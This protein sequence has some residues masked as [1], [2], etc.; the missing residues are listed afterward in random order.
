VN[1]ASWKIAAAMVA[2]YFVFAAILGAFVLL[3]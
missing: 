3:G 2:P 1:V